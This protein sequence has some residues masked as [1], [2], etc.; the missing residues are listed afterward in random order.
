MNKDPL[1]AGEVQ[2]SFLIV[3]AVQFPCSSFPLSCPLTHHGDIPI[4]ASGRA[5]A[6][7]VNPQ[8]RGCQFT[9]RLIQFTNTRAGGFVLTWQETAGK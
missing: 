3:A 8:R 6:G 5:D 2:P 1:I 7:L 4:K 9:A